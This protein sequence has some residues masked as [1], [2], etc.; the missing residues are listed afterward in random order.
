MSSFNFK[1]RNVFKN[2]NTVLPT[3]KLDEVN[4]QVVRIVKP[5]VFSS[6][7][8]KE[9]CKKNTSGTLSPQPVTC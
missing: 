3:G 8:D 4:T 2:K 1:L 6:Y 9:N 5:V 7:Q